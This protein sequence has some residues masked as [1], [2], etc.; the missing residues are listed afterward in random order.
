MASID[1]KF[2]SDTLGMASSMRVLLPEPSIRQIGRGASGAPPHGGKH[3]VLFLLHGLSD[4]ETIWAR[5]TSLERYVAPLGLAVVM[6]NVHRSF[7][8]NM[9]HGYRYWDFVSDELLHKARALFPLSS[10]REHTFVAGLSMGGYGALKLGLSKPE[11]FAR[12]ASMSGSCDLTGLRGRPDELSLVFGTEQ[13]IAGAGGDLLELARALGRSSKPKPK[14]YQC[15]GSQDFL[16]ES[17]RRFRD[18]IARLGFEHFYEEGPGEHDW[19][20]W[21]AAIQRVLAWLPRG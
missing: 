4:D 10:E 6:P 5:F 14:L 18:G 12:A 15:C 9:K 8:T 21:D 1:C 7:Y 19:A 17:N 2:F 20:Y 11:L 3:P 13:D 16:L